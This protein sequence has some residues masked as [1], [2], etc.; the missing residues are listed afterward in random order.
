MFENKTISIIIPSLNSGDTIGRAIIKVYDQ[1]YHNIELI[2]IDGGSTDSTCE[3]VKEYQLKYHNIILISEADQGIYDAMNKGIEASTGDWLY[4][5]GADDEIYDENVLFDLVASGLL[6]QQKIVYGNVVI[7]GSN[8]WAN[9]GDIYDGPFALKKLLAKNICQQS[10]FYPRRVFEKYGKFDLRFNVIADWDFN[11][12]C[13]AQEEFAFLDRVIARFTTGGKSSVIESDRNRIELIKKVSNYFDKDLLDESNYNPQSVFNEFFKLFWNKRLKLNENKD[14][15]KDGIS[16]FTAVKNRSDLLEEALKTWILHPEIDEIIIVDWSSDEPIRS[17][18]ERYQ[19]GKIILV[20]IEKQKHWVLS[21]AFNIA[22]KYTS[23]DKILKLD[24]DVMLHDGFFENH[25][26]TRG[27]FISGDWRIGRNENETHLC[28]NLFIYREDFIKSGG[29]NEYFT[30]YGYDDSDLYD[31]LIELGIE[32]KLFNYDFLYHIEHGKRMSNQQLSDRFKGLTDEEWA[33]FN[34]LKNRSLSKNL[35]KWSWKSDCCDMNILEITE[36]YCKGEI[37]DATYSELSTELITLAENEAIQDRLIELNVLNYDFLTST[38]NEEKLFEIYYM[39]VAEN[40]RHTETKLEIFNKFNE[41][42]Y[43][44]NLEKIGLENEIDLLKHL[45]ELK[46][47]TACQQ[48]NEILELQNKIDE[49]DLQI[50]KNN[51]L[52]KGSLE[53][54]INQNQRIDFNSQILLEKQ[55]LLNGLTQQIIDLKSQIQNSERKRIE[56]QQQISNLNYQ[57]IKLNDEKIAEKTL[58][59]NQIDENQNLTKNLMIEIDGFKKS[60]TYRIIRVIS[61]IL[62]VFHPKMVISKLKKWLIVLSSCRAISRNSLFDGEYYL[63]NNP[64]VLNGG[65]NPAKH[66]LLFGGIEGRNPSEIFDSAF[67][68]KT[69]PDVK[70]TGINPLL[71]YILFGKKEGRKIKSVDHSIKQ[72]V[73]SPVLLESEKQGK[74]SNERAMELILESGLFDITYYCKTYADIREAGVDPLFHFFYTGW[75]ENRNPSEN[76]NTKYYLKSNPD[77]ASSGMNPL[78]HYILVGCAEG[79]SAKPDYNEET[80][81]T[82]SGLFDADFYKEQLVFPPKEMSKVDHFINHG[83]FNE[84]APNRRVAKKILDNSLHHPLISII[85]PVYNSPIRFLSLAI[86][87]VLNQIYQNWELIV[88]D[89]GSTSKETLDYLKTITSTKNRIH[90]TLLEKNQGISN[91]TNRALS[92]VKGDFIAFFDHDDLLTPNCLL[93]IVYSYNQNPET[94]VFYTDQTYIDENGNVTGHFYKP[95]WSPW[96]FRGVMYVC[97]L[98]VVRNTIIKEINGLLPSF[99]F[100]QDFEFMLRV[101]EKAKKIVH[102][103]KTLYHWR[104]I[105]SSVAGGGKREIDFETLQ[106]N[107][108][109]NHLLRLNIPVISKKNPIHPHRLILES[110]IDS[111]VFNVLAIIMT[112]NVISENKSRKLIDSISSAT[113]HKTVQWNVIS[114]KEKNSIT[115]LMNLI[116]KVEYDYLLIINE[117]CTPLDD[118]WLSRL[119][120]FNAIKG[121]GSVGPMIINNEKVISSGLIVSKMGIQNAMNGFDCNSDGYA[122]S[123][124]CIR[125]VSTISP[126]CVVIKKEIIPQRNFILPELGIEYSI[127]NFLFESSLKGNSNLIIP[128]IKVVTDDISCFNYN[129][130]SMSNLYWKNLKA[131]E[132]SF[133][134][135]YYNR[136]FNQTNADYTI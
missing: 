132:L 13:F 42:Q 91:A 81:W 131:K 128:Q 17:L 36:N 22:A 69:Y 46:D 120:S 32:Q 86:D 30:T 61:F 127:I 110:T 58:F 47:N 64:D 9:D 63:K 115:N 105:Q 4:F 68:L 123:L 101:S 89:D 99:D 28:G 2:I 54:I 104:Q 82:M 29:Y 35:G 88:V 121:I 53:E 93:E 16:L 67:Y 43:Q 133:G 11:L 49:K 33:R 96:M 59:Q 50:E 39:N 65:I 83:I 108:V 78:F 18:V 124:C 135:K 5:L 27:S 107:A 136:N 94:D 72:E 12:R 109:N 44:N 100:V 70:E 37:E 21:K 84:I 130:Y 15:I 6:E 117:N 75:K 92:E 38:F 56:F 8:N 80:I 77:V 66:Y 1:Q 20:Q 79:R 106:S 7:K 98:L 24:S 112:E 31:R 25:I 60:L 71:H 57:F 55:Q 10:I 102:I 125:E 90:I 134:D 129:K 119:L 95:D 14:N 19:N 26:L 76:F 3:I 34:I 48:D 113:S 126:F 62:L 114:I 51:D 97:H 103:P 116:N 40:E 74:I 122:G 52:I 85:I 87:S 41:L 45:I 111:S 73:K 23:Y 118:T